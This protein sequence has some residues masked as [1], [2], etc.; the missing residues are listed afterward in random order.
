MSIDKSLI[1]QYLNGTKFIVL[2]TVNDDQTPVLRSLGSFV[3]DG[4]TTYFSTNKN[5]AKVN[6]IKSNPK[7]SILFQHENQELPSFVN[8]SISGKANELTESEE[9]AKA[10]QLIGT[11]NPKFRERAEKGELSDN[12]FFRVEPQEVKVLDFGKG[13]GSE[14]VQVIAV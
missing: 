12:V 6:H 11:R 8:V 1:S 4:L 10:I 3:A 13:A 2:A 9:L 5:S 7:V 14:A